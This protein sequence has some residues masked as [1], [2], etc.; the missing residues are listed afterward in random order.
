MPDRFSIL[1]VDDNTNNLKYL[2]KILEKNNHTVHSSPNARLALNFL[3]NNSPDL[4]LL[5]INMSDMSGIEMCRQLKISEKTTHI[6]VIFISALDKTS[7]KIEA[8]NAGGVDYITKPFQAEEVILRVKTHLQILELQKSLEQKNRLLKRENLERKKAEGALQAAYE[9]ME[10]KVKERTTELTRTNKALQASER[11]FR[12]MFEKASVGANLLDIDKKYI[13]VNPMMCEITGYSEEELLKMS[14]KD[15]THPDDFEEN[16]KL[17]LEI[18]A[19]KTDRA[20]YEKRY[21]HKSGLEINVLIGIF[22]LRDANN[23]PQYFLANLQ[24]VSQVKRLEQQLVQTQ[25]M[26][27][28]G[29]LAGGIAHDFNNILSGI[30]GYAQIIKKHQLGEDHPSV[31]TIDKIIKASQR[32]ADLVKQI[33]TFSRQET[34]EIERVAVTP[35]IK[36]SLKLLKATLPSTVTINNRFSAKNDCVLAHPTM[37]QQI[38]INFCTNAVQ[39]MKGKGGILSVIVEETTLSAV[40]SKQFIRL[41]PGEYLAVTVQ[42]TGTGIPAILKDRVFEPYFTTKPVGEGTGLGLSVVHGIVKKLKGAITVDSRQGEG[43]Q[44]KVYLP[45]LENTGE[46]KPEPLKKDL[47]SG[48]GRIMIVDDESMI[49][50]TIGGMLEELGY[51]VYVQTDSIKALEQVKSS[52]DAFDLLLTDMTMPG[53]RGDQ[54]ARAVLEIRPEFPIILM[55]GFSEQIDEEEARRIGIQH[56]LMKPVSWEDLTAK[57]N[58]IL[59]AKPVVP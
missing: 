49:A 30:M 45:R 40:D 32:A 39:S 41:K 20:I 29:T 34:T 58:L 22:L 16:E 12:T 3:E 6:P 51:Q 54:L 52:P 47:V 28:V 48:T 18:L 27:A 46:G 38:L 5:D 24:D 13:M 26:E 59:E 55:T 36:E 9:G 15:L 7:D 8:F 42:D 50:E 21:L 56:F 11:R 4:I 57:M 35:V 17:H 43:S 23:K 44:F 14:Y 53:M 1:I 33:L 31:V 10:E 25:K 19:G 37:I 2:N